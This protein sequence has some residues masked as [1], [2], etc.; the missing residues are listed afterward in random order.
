MLILLLLGKN[1]LKHGLE[2]G[3]DLLPRGNDEVWWQ[4]ETV[5]VVSQLGR[6]RQHGALGLV[7]IVRGTGSRVCRG[8]M[9]ALCANQ[10]KHFILC[11]FGFRHLHYLS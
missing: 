6:V 9:N 7:P 3:P 5:A 10:A 2:R 4:D 8:R 1:V 11:F